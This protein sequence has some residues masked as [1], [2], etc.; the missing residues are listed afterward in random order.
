M[1]YAPGERTRLPF[2][3]NRVGFPSSCRCR[4][5]WRPKLPGWRQ[6]PMAQQ[7]EQ[8]RGQAEPLPVQLV[9]LAEGLLLKGHWPHPLFYTR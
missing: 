1:H 7:L 5:R 3:A 4:K 9:V 2:C 6:G 8:G